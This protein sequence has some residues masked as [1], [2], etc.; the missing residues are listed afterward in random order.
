MRTHPIHE[1]EVTVIVAGRR[2]SG[3]VVD[4]S[5]LVSTMQTNIALFELWVE[6]LAL[7]VSVK[8]FG[9]V[10]GTRSVSLALVGHLVSHSWKNLSLEGLNLPVRKQ[11]AR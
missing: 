1:V 8:A 5:F 4:V 10:L 11:W 6:N 9:P 3:S 2:C 7:R